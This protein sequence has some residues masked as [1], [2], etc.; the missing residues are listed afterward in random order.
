MWCLRM[1]A[2]LCWER[3][4][5]QRSWQRRAG[6]EQRVPSMWT[7]R[8]RERGSLVCVSGMG[9]LSRLVVGQCGRMRFLLDC[10][11]WPVAGGFGAGDAGEVE[12]DG[13]AEAF[14]VVDGAEGAI[15]GAEEQIHAFGFIGGGIAVEE[16][17]H[18]EAEIDRDLVVI[19]VVAEGDGGEDGLDIGDAMRVD[20]GHLLLEAVF[21]AEVVLAEGGLGAAGSFGIEVT[22]ALSDGVSHV[23][24]FREA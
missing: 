24:S 20:D 16:D 14:D 17:P 13:V 1:I 5:L 11:G 3:W 23:R 18:D 10:V 9:F 12:Q 21:F 15:A 4:L 7:C 2:M 6:L 19:A 22:A 8:Q